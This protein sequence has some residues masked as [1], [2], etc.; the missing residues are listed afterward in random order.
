MLRIPKRL[1]RA[2]NEEIIWTRD[3]DK[4][5]EA[6]KSVEDFIEFNNNDYPHSTLGCISLVDF[7]KQN[8]YSNVA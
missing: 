8:I 2:F 4:F 7:E 6:K 5:D 1:L 3:Y